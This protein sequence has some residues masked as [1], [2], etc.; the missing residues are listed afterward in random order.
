MLNTYTH[1]VGN[2]GDQ[3]LQRRQMPVRK[4]PQQCPA[5]P[6]APSLAAMSGTA[7]VPDGC[8]FREEISNCGDEGGFDISMRTVLTLLVL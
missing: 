8:L 5:L 2:K 3:D 6:R 4:E 7:D 1:D